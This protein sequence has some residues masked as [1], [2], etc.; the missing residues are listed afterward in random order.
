M[1]QINKIEL[2]TEGSKPTVEEWV[3]TLTD[4]EQTEFRESEAREIARQ[5]GLIAEGKMIRH[6]DGSI[7]FVDSQ[8][9]QGNYYDTDTVWVT[10]FNRWL[11]ETGQYQ[12][13]TVEFTSE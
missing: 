6:Q 11:S 5:A 12:Q 8:A 13:T 2:V 1:T 4:A 9:A 10:Y 7:E 3:A